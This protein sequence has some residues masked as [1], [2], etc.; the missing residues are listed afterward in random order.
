MPPRPHNAIQVEA[1]FISSSSTT[2][3]IQMFGGKVS[4]EPHLV[5]APLSGT[6]ETPRQ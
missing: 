5:V 4:R 1:L 2:I 3:G 6:Y